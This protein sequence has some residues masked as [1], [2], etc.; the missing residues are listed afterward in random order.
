MSWRIRQRLGSH[1][2]RHCPR[3]GLLLPVFRSLPHLGGRRAAQ[4]GH[5]TKDPENPLTL[6]DLPQAID[7]LRLAGLLPFRNAPFL[8]LLEQP[9][10]LLFLR[11]SSSQ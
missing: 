10:S 8:V 9:P 4:V 3:S 7:C 5:L 2:F 11:T 6:N 1:R